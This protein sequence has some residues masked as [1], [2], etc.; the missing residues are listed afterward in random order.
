M[1]TH[2]YNNL[3]LEDA[4]NNLGTMFDCAVHAAQCDL[5]VFYEMFLSSGVASQ[6]E[7]GNPR[8]LSGM[9]GMELM[10]LVLEKSS[11]KTMPIV[12][13]VPFDRTP[14]YWAGWAL[15]YYQWCSAYSFAFIQRNG[16]SISTV[17]SLYPTLHE[18]DLSKF[19]QTADALIQRH[20]DT[21]KNRLKTIRKQSR[22]TQKE[23][24]DLSGVTLR[25]IQAYE[26]GDQDIL[27]AEAQTVFALS[28]VLGCAPEVICG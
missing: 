27:K 17:L 9:S 3:Y 7:A 6:M 28:R 20:L 15:A 14:E 18:A 25:M 23:L 5:L 4:M 21:R 24:A 19:V 11:D 1:K 22:F 2:A 8:Y 16:L 10:Q 12:N 26:Q 13:Y